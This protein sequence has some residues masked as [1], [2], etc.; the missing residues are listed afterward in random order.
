MEEVRRPP[1]S[2]G[3][4]EEARGVR[5][6]GDSVWP[7]S[8]PILCGV[9]PQPYGCVRDVA[10]APRRADGMNAPTPGAPEAPAIRTTCANSVNNWLR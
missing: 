8:S 10:R 3:E 5:G 2:V 7:I 6:P 4:A 1:Q 9:H